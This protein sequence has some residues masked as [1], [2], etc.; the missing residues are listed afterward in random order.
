VSAVEGLVHAYER[1]VRLPWDA[2]LAGPQ[3]VWF[4]IYDPSQE[5]RLRWRVEEFASATR[6]AGHGWRLVDLTDAFA[7]WMASHE[8][9]EAYFEHPEGMDLTLRQDFSAFVAQHVRSTLNAPDVDD[10]TVVAVL[11][12][13]SLFGLTRASSLFEAVAPDIRGRL[14][15]FFPGQRD[16]SKYRLLDAGEGWN[17]L[18]IPITADGG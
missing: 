1:F 12:L 7:R 5:R 14:L 2:S 6:N 4:A 17:Y 13:A 9:R 16:G 10:S 8:Y 11:G 18:A 3:R 15:G